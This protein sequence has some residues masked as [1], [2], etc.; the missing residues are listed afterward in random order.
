MRLFV[1]LAP[2]TAV[3]N[4]LDAACTPLRPG[5]ILPAGLTLPEALI[6]EIGR[7]HV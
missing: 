5:L 4:D 7:A 2:P 1:G 6:L 3:L